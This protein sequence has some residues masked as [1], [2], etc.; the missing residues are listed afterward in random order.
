MLSLIKTDF[1]RVLGDKLFL[2]MCIIAG[3]FALITPL[4]YLIVFGMETDPMAAE[5]LGGIGTARGVFFDAFSLGNNFGLIGP[6]FLSIVLMK[7]F[8]FGTVRNKIISGHKRSTIFLSMY[9]VCAAVM[10]GVVFLQA[11]VSFAV[12]LIVF[13]LGIEASEIGFVLLSLLLEFLLYLAVSAFIC[14]LC[15]AMK[16]VGL[17]LV[18]YVA[19]TMALTM[20]ASIIMVIILVLEAEGTG[21]TAVKILEVLQNI[22]I[23]NYGTLIGKGSSYETEQLC[24]LA[25]TPVVMTVGFVGLGILKFNRKDIK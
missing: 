10:F 8:S 21:E 7:D 24:Y 3:V 13:D 6:V 25:A 2:V 16:N 4:L 19:A 22:N 20:V 17:V 18:L 1:K 12:G 9:T 15:A 11:L 14:W 5:F 23:F